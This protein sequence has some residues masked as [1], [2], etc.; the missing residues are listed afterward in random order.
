MPRQQDRRSSDHFLSIFI[1]T[2]ASFECTT[3]E[4]R[5]T[6]RAQAASCQVSKTNHPWHPADCVALHFIR[7]RYF[8][9][10]IGIATGLALALTLAVHLVLALSR[11]W[12]ISNITIRRTKVAP[13]EG[14]CGH[15][16]ISTDTSSRDGFGFASSHE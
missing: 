9:I 15:T 3:P 2:V 1:I 10:G 6:K 4:K 7:D 13:H 8:N 16:G 14:W 11:P 5:S 12:A